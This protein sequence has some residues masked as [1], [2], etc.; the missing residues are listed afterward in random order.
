MDKMEEP[1]RR[2]NVGLEEYSGIMGDYWGRM[3]DR[4][5]D[6]ARK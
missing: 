4:M 2:M 1:R 6:N 3:S 5:K